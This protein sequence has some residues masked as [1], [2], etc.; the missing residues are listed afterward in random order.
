MRRNSATPG[1]QGKGQ[2]LSRPRRGGLTCSEWQVDD[3]LSK[4]E[5][6]E[7][8]PSSSTETS[9]SEADPI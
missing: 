1:A 9:P 7:G 8:E 2:A 4:G 5:S 3:V 6:T